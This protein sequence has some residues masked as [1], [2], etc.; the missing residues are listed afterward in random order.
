MICN[1][2]N[3]PLNI[4]GKEIICISANIRTFKKNVVYKCSFK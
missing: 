1:V 3:L 2:Y 4:K